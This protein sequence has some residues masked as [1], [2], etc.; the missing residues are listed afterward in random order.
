MGSTHGDTPPGYGYD[1]EPYIIEHRSGSIYEVP[2]LYQSEAE[3]GA[4]GVTSSLTA[5]ATQ[6]QAGRPVTGGFAEEL[7]LDTGFATGVETATARE[8]ESLA[9]SA[10]NRIDP[11]LVPSMQAVATDRFV[12]R[13]LRTFLE[14]D[15]G[16][17][18][19][20][21]NDSGRY[22]GDSLPPTINVGI[23]GGALDTRTTL[24]HELLHYV[25]DKADT[26]IGEARDT[27]GAD[28]PAIIAIES[29]FLI[30]DLIRSGHPP[31]HEKIRSSFGQFLQGRDFF[32]VMEE[33]IA[34]NNHV[35][36]RATVDDPAFVRSTV[37]SGLLPTASALAFPSGPTRYHYTADQFRDLAFIW[38]QSAVIV[39]R[40]MRTAVDVSNRTGTP[41]R[42]VFGHADWRREMESFL[43]RFVGALRRD[44]T[45]GVVSL[46]ARL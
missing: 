33:S 20:W 14:T 4:S 44:R 19:A 34:R 39:R 41:L 22:D 8:V 7:A 31:L 6:R 40:A 5:S 21:N 46:E 16:R 30:I 36:L 17:L 12:Y 11:R 35:A 26:V 1:R 27:G 2:G 42:D 28:H 29:R 24:V 23:A 38:A 13:A 10:G 3:Y 37:S 9:R 18:V 32:P 43:D 45:R 15:N 25:F